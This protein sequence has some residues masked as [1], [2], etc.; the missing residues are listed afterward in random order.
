M[1]ALPLLLTLAACSPDIGSGTYFCGPERLCPPNLGCDDS[2]YTCMRP[3]AV[4]PFACPEDAEAAEPDGSTDQAD[5]RGDLV[6]GGAVSQPDGCIADGDQIDVL[7][8]TV[9]TTC[10][11]ADPHL[12]VTLRFPI[13]LVPLRV[14]LLDAGGQPLAAGQECTPDDDFTGKLY[15]CIETPLDP[16]DYFLQ[17]DI[18][19]DGGDCGGDC[20]HNSYSL[21]VLFPLS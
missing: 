19:P 13:A 2:T 14:Q 17:V 5:Q 4:E 11:G 7:A 9:P 16:G 3:A 6:C 18:D 8:F 21:D 20:R 1:R 12:A 10:L 15:Q